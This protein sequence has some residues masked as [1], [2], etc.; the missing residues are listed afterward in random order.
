MLTYKTYFHSKASIIKQTV[1]LY[2]WLL[3]SVLALSA[4]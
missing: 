4:V 1:E 3:A 2:Q